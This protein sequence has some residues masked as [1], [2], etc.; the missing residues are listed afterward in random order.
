[1]KIS[2]TR[3]I[4]II[5]EVVDAYS[6]E[7]GTDTVRVPRTRSRDARRMTPEEAEEAAA[8]GRRNK[9]AARAAE[10]TVSPS[11]PKTDDRYGRHAAASD[12]FRAWNKRKGQAPNPDSIIAGTNNPW[13][14]DDDADPEGLDPDEVGTQTLDLDP[15]QSR[16]LRQKESKMKISKARLIEIIKEE[17]SVINEDWEGDVD[18][19][20]IDDHEAG[21][22]TRWEK[23]KQA[24]EDDGAAGR[25]P[26][27]PHGFASKYYMRAYKDAFNRTAGERAK[28]SRQGLKR[29][30][31]DLERKTQLRYKN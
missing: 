11:A 19:E 3:F 22:P 31:S 8:L 25:E 16:K 24:G 15:E 5:R 30:A 27:P 10:K 26:T 18:D 28:K 13:S 7:Q 21:R 14:A 2:K 6:R 1:M 20:R 17:L 4:E 9:M 29:R 12:L 23:A